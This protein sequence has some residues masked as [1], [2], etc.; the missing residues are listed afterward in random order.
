MN[1]TSPI[2]GL[3]GGSGISPSKSSCAKEVPGIRKTFGALGILGEEGGKQL[4]NESEILITSARLALGFALTSPG[5]RRPARRYDPFVT[6][7]KVSFFSIMSIPNVFKSTMCV[8]YCAGRH[9]KK[10]SSIEVKYG[11]S[12]NIIGTSFLL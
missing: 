7:R 6:R 10:W 4:L 8:Y 12:H 5:E 3:G 11:T 9:E 2:T 1:S